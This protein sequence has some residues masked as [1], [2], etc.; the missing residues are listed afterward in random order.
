MDGIL[1]Q[2]ARQAARYAYR[3]KR[4]KSLPC[5]ICGSRP[6]EMHHPDYTKPIDVVWLCVKHHKELHWN[7]Y[8][9]KPR[10]KKM[11]KT[12]ELRQK[13]RETIARLQREALQ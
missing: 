1:K 2:K 11:T 4:F 7:S 3:Q 12:E 5:A 8:V 10:T 6:T 13:H 9:K